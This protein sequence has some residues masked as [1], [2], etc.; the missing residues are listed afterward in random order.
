VI[1]KTLTASAIPSFVQGAERAQLETAVMA[2]F[3][4]S[5]RWSMLGAAGIA[6]LSALFSAIM[7]DRGAGGDGSPSRD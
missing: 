3:V 5:F 7:I 6:L 4:Q 1:G 2:A